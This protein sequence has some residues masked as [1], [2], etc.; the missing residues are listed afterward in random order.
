[1]R[2]SLNV[3]VR[4]ENTEPGHNKFWQA[5]LHSRVVKVSWGPIGYEPRTLKHSFHSSLEAYT[6]FQKKIESKLGR[7]YR[8]A[9]IV[10]H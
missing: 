9:D 7:G 2:A 5:L 10:Q 1:M 8:I 3:A 6:F 4:L